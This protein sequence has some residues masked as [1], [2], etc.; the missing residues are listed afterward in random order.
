M[1][2]A[3][4]NHLLKKLASSSGQDRKQWGEQIAAEDIDVM[5][6]MPLLRADKKTAYRFSWLLSDIGEA[7]P[8][9]LFS[10]LDY[11]FSKRQQVDIPGFEQQ[12]AKYWRIAGIPQQDEGTAIDLLFQWLA[13]PAT[14]VHIKAVSMEVLYRLTG[15]YPEL[16]NE[17]IFTLH[18]QLE[19]NTP[20]FK[21]QAQKLLKKLQ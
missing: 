14:G 19:H 1:P 4:Y 3:F 8:Q 7:A 5:E 6:L 9:K 10:V 2:S 15:A 16:K 21:K 17:L 12:F 13:A 11:A 20:T 18:D